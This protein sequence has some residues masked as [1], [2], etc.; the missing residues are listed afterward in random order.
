MHKK[1]LTVSL[2]LTALL[3]FIGLMPVHGEEAIYHSTVRL[4]VI[5]ASDSEEDQ[6]IKL[7]VRDAILALTNPLLADCASQKE[8]VARLEANKE[9]LKE[10]ARAVLT[11][12]GREDA[13]EIL[14]GTEEYPTRSYDAFCFP[15]G[16]Y[17]SLRVLIG[18]G[19]GKNWWCCLFPPLCLGAATVSR[20]NAEDACI[21]VGLTPSQ[22]QIITESDRPVYRVRFKLLELFSSAE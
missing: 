2:A 9:S 17:V 21:S 22:Y 7:E 5:A 8:A 3:L 20:Q 13:V 4:H 15:A 18:S 16:E 14:L 1:L 12:A 10:A 19:E 6:S 11:R